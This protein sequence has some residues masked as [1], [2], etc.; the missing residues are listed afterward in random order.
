MSQP[1]LILRLRDC[2]ISNEHEAFVKLAQTSLQS[3]GLPGSHALIEEVWAEV[4]L[5]IEANSI[6]G[7]LTLTAYADNQKILLF[8]GRL[9]SDCSATWIAALNEH[10]EIQIEYRTD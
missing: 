2:R 4:A 8:A 3:Q 7:H 9:Q 6:N 10:E 5:K 1:L